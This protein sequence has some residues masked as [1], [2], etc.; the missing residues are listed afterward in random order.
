MFNP[1]NNT[2][3]RG[4][5]AL[6]RGTNAP[7]IGSFQR[8]RSARRIVRKSPAEPLPKP[9]STVATVSANVQN[10][11]LLARSTRQIRYADN[12]AAMNPRDDS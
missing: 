2:D 7:R 4:I 9:Q 12:H 11:A 3:T 10:R 1:R 8:S 5:S 6:A